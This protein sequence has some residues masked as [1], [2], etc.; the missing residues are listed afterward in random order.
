[1]TLQSLFLQLAG[2]TS[3]YEIL[4]DQ[5]W[6]E[7]AAG[8]SQ[9]DR[10]YH[11]LSHLDN[12]VSELDLCRQQI[13][14]YDTLLYAIFYHDL[15]YAVQRQDNEAQS[16]IL[17]VSR[18]TTLGLDLA[19]TERCR[20][21]ILATQSHRPG[22]D[23]DTDLFTDADLSILGKGQEVYGQYSRQIRQEYIVYPDVLYFPGRAKV[24]QHFLGMSRI[25]KTAYFYDLY[26]KQARLNLQWELEQLQ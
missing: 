22:D 19:R 1:M 11:N 9:P 15:I 3:H 18:L 14:D 24:L 13:D 2:R 5:L 4:F 21:H 25:Y 23:H 8:Y 12:L 16:A 20:R 6:Q 7:I 26:E 10:Y 17:A